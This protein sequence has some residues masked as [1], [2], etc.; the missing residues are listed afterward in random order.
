MLPTNQGA[1]QPL[2]QRPS[3][4]LHQPPALIYKPAEDLFSSCHRPV[5]VLT[6]LLLQP[7]P[8]VQPTSADGGLYQ[9]LGELTS[10]HASVY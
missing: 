8:Q 6:P 10:S 9:Q 2:P 5:I 4:S 1:H 3:D 7:S